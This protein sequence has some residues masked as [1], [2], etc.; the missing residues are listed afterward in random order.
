MES[1]ELMVGLGYTTTAPCMAHEQKATD[2]P[3]PMR[4]LCTKCMHWVETTSEGPRH[5]FMAGCG[6]LPPPSPEDIKARALTAKF[7]RKHMHGCKGSVRAVYQSDRI[8][9]ALEALDDAFREDK[10]D[11]G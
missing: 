4:L 3:Q 7:M 5:L 11:A 9:T 1:L 8:W 10:S 6:V 2:G